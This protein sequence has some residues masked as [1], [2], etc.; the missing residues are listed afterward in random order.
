MIKT[1]KNFEIY[2]KSTSWQ[3]LAYFNI[4]RILLSGLFI[5]LS[6]IGQLP[7]PL[8]SFDDQLFTRVSL[9]YLTIAIL[10]S[11]FIH[12]QFPRFNLQIAFHVL[13]DVIMLSLLMYS[14]N[15]LSSGFGMLLVIAI[16]GGSILRAGKIAILF[17]AIATIAVLAHELYL[18]FFLFY[19]PV[20]Y[21]HAGILGATFFITA[22]IGNLL[23]ARVE[24]TKALAEKQAIEINELAKLNEHIVQRMQAGIIVI[25]SDMKVLLMNESAKHFFQATNSDTKNI[26]DQVPEILKK[27]HG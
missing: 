2:D 19:E 27:S 9:V 26:E 4:Y 21:T 10:C 25:D 18:Q 20:N 15:G 6:Q 13:I 17:A 11:I 8:G 24:E 23:S 7:E 1:N 16:A 12:K 5:I 22:F 3:A 14:S